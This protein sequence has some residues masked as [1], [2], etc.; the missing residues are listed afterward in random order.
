M[1]IIRGIWLL[2]YGNILIITYGNICW[3]SYEAYVVIMQEYCG[4]P[5]RNVMLIMR[6]VCSGYYAGNNG[7]HHT[8]NKLLK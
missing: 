5:T 8:G 1:V 7:V 4:Y 6:G 3:L 2:L